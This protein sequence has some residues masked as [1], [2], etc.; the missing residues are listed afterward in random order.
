MACLEE[1]TLNCGLQEVASDRE[2]AEAEASQGS[3]SL[4]E[5]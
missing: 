1:R 4:A 5:A 3:P 2:D